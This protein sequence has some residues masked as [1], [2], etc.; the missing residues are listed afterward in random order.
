M[1]DGW[2]EVGTDQLKISY[3]VV[4]FASKCQPIPI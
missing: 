4:Q 1:V 2:Q 3:V